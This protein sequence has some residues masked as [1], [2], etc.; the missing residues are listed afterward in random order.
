METVM[1]ITF[2][3]VLPPMFFRHFIN[4][5]TKFISNSFLV[6]KPDKFFCTFRIPFPVGGRNIIIRSSSRSS[7]NQMSFLA[8][9]GREKKTSRMKSMPRIQV[10]TQQLFVYKDLRWPGTGRV[11][12]KMALKRHRNSLSALVCSSEFFT[13]RTIRNICN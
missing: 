7:K 6:L 10:L 3:Y 5:Y 1:E 9:L 12:K 13:R 2:R 11:G 8:A 4:G